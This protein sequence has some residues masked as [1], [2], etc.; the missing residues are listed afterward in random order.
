MRSVLLII[1]WLII[2]I[3]FA[4]LGVKAMDPAIVTILMFSFT[5]M[6][7]VTILLIE[8]DKMNDRAIAAIFS[9]VVVIG[10][11]LWQINNI[12]REA[13]VKMIQMEDRLNQEITDSRKSTTNP[14]QYIEYKCLKGKHLSGLFY[15]N[16]ATV[17]L[18]DSRIFNLQRT[19]SADGQRF[20][21]ENDKT[22]FWIKGET[23][24]FDEGSKTVYEGCEIIKGQQ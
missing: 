2:I 9:F 6:Y 22:V 3:A 11:G 23:A 4:A 14:I 15:E 8:E 7:F 20:A 17:T 21:S 16:S 5:A 13:D 10:L 12:N 24:R 19:V 18:S 1:P